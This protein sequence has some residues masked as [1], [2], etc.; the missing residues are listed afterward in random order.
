MV[1]AEHHATPAVALAIAPAA[2]LVGEVKL[3]MGARGFSKG[4]LMKRSN[5]SRNLI[6]ISS[7]VLIPSSKK[8]SSDSNSDRHGLTS[9]I[10][11]TEAFA[12]EVL[13][14]PF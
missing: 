14:A 10:G 1:L 4:T 8:H 12:S 9:P 2:I 11:Q 3:S 5:L 6:F 7:Q 13:T